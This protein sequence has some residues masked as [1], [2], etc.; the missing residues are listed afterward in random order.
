MNGLR[1]HF[2]TNSAKE[3]EGVEIEFPEAT[4]NDKT[5]P[6]FV[7]SRMGKANKTYAKALEAK[8]RPFR[9]QVE[10]GTMKTEVADELFLNVFVD[11]ILRGW[12]HVQDDNGAEIP[13]TRE[14]AIAL[15]TEPG[16]EDLY[17]RLQ[18]EAGLSANFRDLKL[19][20]EAGN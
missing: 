8:T 2:K 17:E 11:T 7:L 15:L 3:V 13:F 9:R 12:R 16:M 19:E 4:N 1:K 6:V 14:N 20:S 5:V 10:L 18:T